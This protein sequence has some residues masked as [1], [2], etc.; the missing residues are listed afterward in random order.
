M[1]RKE[2][3]KKTF[4]IT[5]AIDELPVEFDATTHMMATTQWEGQNPGKVVLDVRVKREEK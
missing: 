5:Y 4:L 1:A 2:A 3:E